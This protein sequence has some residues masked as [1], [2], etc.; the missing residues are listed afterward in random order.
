[1]LGFT[2]G[3]EWVIGC[4]GNSGI[5]QYLIDY[6]LYCK[7]LT[8]LLVGC[9]VQY[10]YFRLGVE[11]P[12]VSSEMSSSAFLDGKLHQLQNLIK[13]DPGAYIGKSATSQPLPSLSAPPNHNCSN[14]QLNFLVPVSRKLD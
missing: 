9:E 11:G 10:H 8:G 2:R 13:R 1:M 14:V 7:V 5:F 4:D 12:V 3:R 6:I